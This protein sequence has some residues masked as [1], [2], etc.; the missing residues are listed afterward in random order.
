MIGDAVPGQCR[1]PLRHLAML[2]GPRRTRDLAVGH[3]ADQGVPERVLHLVLDGRDLCRP[4]QLLAY[5]LVQLVPNLALLDARH[6]RQGPGPEHPAD[7]GGV[8]QQG[9]ALG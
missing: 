1:G 3:V 8:L 9:L 6:G 2:L 4:N 7:D 5:Q